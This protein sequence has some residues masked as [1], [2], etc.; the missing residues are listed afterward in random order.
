MIR[1]VELKDAEAI[2]TIYNDAVL[3]TTAIYANDP[4]TVANREQWIKESWLR[5]GHYL[6]LN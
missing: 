2:Q 4:V 1:H 5:T 6:C 3:N